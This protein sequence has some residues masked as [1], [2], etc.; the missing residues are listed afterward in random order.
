MLKVSRMTI[1]QLMIVICLSAICVLLWENRTLRC[2]NVSVSH[3]LRSP[4]DFP[5][6]E[7]TVNHTTK[8][9]TRLVNSKTTLVTTP[10]AITEATATLVHPLQEKPLSKPTAVIIF[11][12]MRSGSSFLG[13]LF[14]QHSQVFYMFEP[15]H[16]FG[17]YKE[18]RENRFRALHDI[19]RCN[20]T[21]LPNM[22][23]QAVEGG[24]APDQSSRCV[25]DNFC[26]KFK[27]LFLSRDTD[28]CQSPWKGCKVPFDPQILSQVCQ[29]SLFPVSKVIAEPFLESLEPIL[30]DSRVEL[31]VIHLVRDP[32]AVMSSRKDVFSDAKNTFA[33]KG[34]VN[35]L[36]N[37]QRRNL[38]FA[39]CM[40]SL[41][42]GVK[43]SRL[44]KGRYKR[45]RFEDVSARPLEVAREVYN[46]VGLNFNSIIEK[47][48]KLNT[49]AEASQSSNKFSTKRD[50]MSAVGHW[51]QSLSLNETLIIQ[52]ACFDN[53][54]KLNYTLISNEHDLN[55]T[56]LN[57]W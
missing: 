20:F 50:S 49:R 28:L 47:W 3:R 44:W 48:I 53:M 24:Y 26:F 41:C 55:N 9:K 57:L 23:K 1:S 35:Y 27:S 22:Y 13:E 21:N 4:A 11:T 16:A 54:S 18:Q 56:K 19:S 17:S 38:R 8:P 46:F 10:V 39:E 31:R 5:Y 34:N 7:P 37:S 40:N 30:E 42:D 52:S 15:L 2:R 36:C 6:D 43:P 51:R 45:L 14:N 29:R 33:I 25:E 32:R 12:S